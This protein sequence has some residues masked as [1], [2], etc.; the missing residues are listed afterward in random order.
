M[1]WGARA[2]AAARC[3]GSSRGASFDQNIEPP[4]TRCSG[5]RRRSNRYDDTNSRGV[6]A[7]VNMN[8]L[9]WK[10]AAFDQDL[11]WCVNDD[12]DLESAFFGTKCAAGCIFGSDCASLSCGVA[13]G[14]ARVRAVVGA[15][16]PAFALRRSTTPTTPLTKAAGRSTR[17]TAAPR[18]SS[19]DTSNRCTCRRAPSA[20][21][22][23]ASPRIYCNS[24]AAE[25]DHE[26]RELGDL[27]AWAATPGEDI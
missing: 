14:A 22:S 6:H 25:A 18:V 3:S 17:R 4:C 19:V 5:R 2:A 1:F 8:Y 23:R 20:R 26:L 11:G 9:F 7:V 12:V 15:A 21:S 16:V 24:R 13:R 10:A 27:H